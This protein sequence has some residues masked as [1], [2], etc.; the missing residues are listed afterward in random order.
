MRNGH[1]EK[2][3][4]KCGELLVSHAMSGVQGDRGNS[5]VFYLFSVE[6]N[7]MN[8]PQN[9][10]RLHRF[11]PTNEY[12]NRYVVC[13]VW[14]WR[15]YDCGLRIHG[16]QNSHSCLSL[17][18]SG[19]RCQQMFSIFQSIFY[20]VTCHPNAF[21]NGTDCSLEIFILFCGRWTWLYDMLYALWS[22]AYVCAS[23]RINI[24]FI[25][26]CVSSLHK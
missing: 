26:L 25:L 6:S 17:V 23:S 1:R 24:H 9:D 20:I 8:S 4:L 21:F 10:C 19:G 12:L 3:V 2:Y 16:R 5:V 15:W 14:R 18:N 22:A 11:C 13:A 7:C